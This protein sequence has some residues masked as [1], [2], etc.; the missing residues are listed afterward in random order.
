VAVDPSGRYAYSVNERSDDV[1]VF[2]IDGSTGALTALQVAP[3]G[4]NPS[5]MVVTS[6]LR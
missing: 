1:S 2:R 4:L 5:T 6:E 3:A